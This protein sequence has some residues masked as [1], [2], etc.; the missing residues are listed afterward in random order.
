M[1]KLRTLLLLGV[2]SVIAAMVGPSTSLAANVVK[3]VPGTLEIRNGQNPTDP[4]NCSAVAFIAWADV[5][6]TISAT[7]KWEQFLDGGWGMRSKTEQ[8]PFNDTYNFIANYQVSPGLHWIFIGA[9]WADG[10]L[11]ND[12]SDMAAR[13]P[14][15][16]RGAITVEL[17]IPESAACVKAKRNVTKLTKSVKSLKSKVKKSSGSKKKKY[18]KQLRKANA[19]LKST[20]KQVARRCP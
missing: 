10:P 13:T 20:K 3:T 9:S 12:C 5:P 8:P 18:K 17:T 15:G 1:K 4:G 7:A 16:F 6:G 19:S 14:N 2:V 11:P